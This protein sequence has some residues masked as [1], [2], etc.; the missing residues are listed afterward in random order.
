MSI[1]CSMYMRISGPI[2]KL[3]VATSLN[4]PSDVFGDV[5][6]DNSDTQTHMIN[7][8][9][10]I[11][12]TIQRNVG[13]PHMDP[14]RKDRLETFLFG[15]KCLMCTVVCLKSWCMSTHFQEIVRNFFTN[16]HN[17]NT[18]IHILTLRNNMMFDASNFA[19][20]GLSQILKAIWYDVASY[21]ANSCSLVVQQYFNMIAVFAATFPRDPGLPSE[22]GVIE[23]KY[24]SFRRWLYN[25]IIIWQG[26]PGSLRILFS[27]S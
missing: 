13:I 7:M 19:S 4:Q 27:N 26:E 17:G 11:Y 22:N 15:S 24:L 5:K 6:D 1:H 21:W 10:Y 12:H 3:A 25:P 8:I 2:L 9:S 23:P 16:H 14:M 18:R 20:I